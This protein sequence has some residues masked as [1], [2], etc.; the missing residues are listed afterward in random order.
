VLDNELI[1][2]K[3]EDIESK[4]LSDWKAGKEGPATDVIFDSFFQILFGMRLRTV[5]ESQLVNVEKL[6]DT[7]PAIGADYQLSMNGPIMAFDHGYGKVSFISLPVRHNYKVIT[8]AKSVGSEHPFVG[9]TVIDALRKKVATSH[10]Q[11]ALEAFENILHDNK[12]ND[13]IIQDIDNILS[14]PEVRVVRSVDDNL[15]HAVVIR[16]IFDKK[17]QQK[18]LR[19]FIYGFPNIDFFEVLDYCSKKMINLF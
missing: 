16:D 3:G 1:S 19:F 2:S 10:P 17:V 12:V 6:L 14:G 4:I 13:F 5:G 18:N 8:I 9:P 15:F 11:F 7:M